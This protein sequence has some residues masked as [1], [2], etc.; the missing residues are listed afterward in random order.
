MKKLLIIA[1]LFVGCETNESKIIGIWE[2]VDSDGE[3]V[4]WFFKKD[5]TFIILQYPEQSGKWEIDKNILSL[6]GE[7]VGDRTWVSPISF[8]GDSMLWENIDSGGFYGFKR[9]WNP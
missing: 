1:L 9:F 3:I 4:K 7:F 6:S 8:S 2:K 5:G